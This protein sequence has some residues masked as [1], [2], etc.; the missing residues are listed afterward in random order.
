[1]FLNNVN[2]KTVEERKKVNNVVITSEYIHKI[3]CGR[4]N[5]KNLKNKKQT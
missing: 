4:N 3:K 5:T 1:M 2:E